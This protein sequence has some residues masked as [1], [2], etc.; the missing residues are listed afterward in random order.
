MEA[1]ERA[2]RQKEAAEKQKQAFLV[3]RFAKMMPD[4]SLRVQDRMNADLKEA[5]LSC[6]AFNSL[7]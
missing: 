1:A 2:A 6:G 4:S 7:H 3:Q 5:R